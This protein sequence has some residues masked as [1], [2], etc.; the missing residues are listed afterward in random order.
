[1]AHV[2]NFEIGLGYTEGWR[3]DVFYFVMKGPNNAI[4]RCQPRDP[5]LFNWPALRLAV[6]RKEKAQPDSG[7]RSRRP[8]LWENILADFPVI[9]KSFNLSYAGRDG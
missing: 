9:N 2:D 7:S 8:G 4:F 1:M 3:G 6:S 5:S